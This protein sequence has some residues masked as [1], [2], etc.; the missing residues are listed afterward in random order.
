L[1]RAE[2]V[3]GGSVAVHPALTLLHGWAHA[4]IPVP[5]ADWQ[6][7]YAGVVRFFAPAIGFLVAL[8]FGVTV[9]GIVADWTTRAARATR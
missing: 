1:N 4:S 3:P 8:G 2:K 5:Y 9:R 6:G 7:V